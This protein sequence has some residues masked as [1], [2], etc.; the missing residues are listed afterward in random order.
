VTM[1][2]AHAVAQRQRS[3][4]YTKLVAERGQGGSR[5]A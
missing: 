4:F 5:Y 2:Q 1:R 3:V